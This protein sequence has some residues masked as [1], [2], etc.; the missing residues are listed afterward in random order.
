M[1][2]L[3]PTICRFSQVSVINCWIR[4]TWQLHG[5]TPDPIED[6]TPDFTE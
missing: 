3:I 4:Q 6:T 1:D 2:P 5:C